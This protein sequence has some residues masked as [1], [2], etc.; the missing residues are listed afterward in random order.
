GSS[1]TMRQQPVRGSRFG[2]VIWIPMVQ[3]DGARGALSLQAFEAGAYEQST[4][5]FAEQVADQASLALRNAWSYSTSE[6]HRRRLEVVNGVGRRLI[7]SLDR[8]SI[9]RALREELALHLQFDVFILASIREVT[10]G[11][12]LAEGYGYDS[13]HEQ[14]VPAVPLAVAGPSREAYESKS[15]V[16]LRSNPWARV[17][18]ARRPAHESFVATDGAAFF[19]SRP[20]HRQR[21]IARSLIWVPV[22]HG[23]RV[24]ALL[25]VQSYRDGAFSEAD[26]KLLQDIAAHVSLALDN[27]DHYGEA[28]TERR[29]L[30]A[31]HVVELGI[32]AAVDERGIAEAVFR[33]LSQYLAVDVLLLVYIDAEARLSGFTLGPSAGFQEIAP[34]PVERTR[35]FARVLATGLTLEESVQDPNPDPATILEDGDD[36]R[37][38]K[39]VLWV[40][41]FQE[42]RAVAA[43]SGQRFADLPFVESDVQL[44]ESAAPVVGIALRTVR[45]HRANQLALDHSLRI[46]E[47]A[48]LA[49]HDLTSTVASIA[50]QALAML[51]SAGVCCWAFDA[52]GRVSG[53]RASGN[54]R[55]ERVLTWAGWRRGAERGREPVSGVAGGRGWMLL[56]LW[57]GDRL[58]G[59][60]G[61]VHG[62]APVGDPGGAELDFARH[63]AVA[64]EN[65]RL[66]AETRG[67]I[68]TLEAVAAFTNLDPTRL[69]RTHAEMARLIERALAPAGALWLMDEDG[70]V[71]AG[72]P[73]RQ[74]P[75]QDGAWLLQAL[76]AERQSPR[77]RD[78]LAGLGGA[79][80]LAAPVILDGLLAGLLTARA[81]EAP[82]NE[83]RRLM[84]VLAGQAGVV[85]G[86]L[87]LVG[88]LERERHM[89]NAILDNSP[90]GVTLQDGGGH[91]VYANPAVERLYGVRAEKIVSRTLESV[92]DEA[93]TVPMSSGDAAEPGA[94]E[95][96]MASP[97]RV[98]RLRTV[99]MP[100]R[101]DEEAEGILSLHEDVT[102]QRQVM[103]AK[104]FMLRAIGHEVRSPAAAMRN[105][106][107]SVIQWEHQID[108]QQRGA[109]VQEAYEMSD[110]LLSLVEGQLI[111]SKLE[112]RHFEPDSTPVHLDQS[113]QQVMAVLAHRY[114][115][116]IEAVTIRLEDGLPAAYCEPTH[117]SQVLTNLVGNALEYTRGS[118]EVAARADGPWLEITVGDDG[119]GLPG[120][121][122]EMLFQKTGA[123]GR[124]RARGGLGLGLYLCRLVVERSFGGR[125]WLDKTGAGATFR[126]TVP[127][128]R[129]A[130]APAPAET[131]SA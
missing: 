91:I 85:L 98:V 38:P 127:S 11:E 90:V 20:G 31:L 125:I 123:A 63:A 109:L 55:A 128:V 50:E 12:P 79:D 101:G 81:G 17:V 1:V 51:G 57:Y 40:P 62:S 105:M 84:S 32:A 86:R 33:G 29:R 43:L 108:S 69:E 70:L 9:M 44:L 74:V 34:R 94:R 131:A 22:L 97:D 117:L 60:L 6:A 114:G 52:E 19:V 120:E 7:S 126:F 21:T 2:S 54:R 65:A 89:M 72:D 93:G 68:W 106:L 48:A 80:L 121:G 25:S 36:R 28:Q 67:R 46:Q 73:G 95:V 107:A 3:A 58:V 102:Q 42:G 99:A 66:A 61:S 59:A 116:R 18:E 96:R 92:L 8:W 113:V 115:G 83:T 27:A 26:V 45:L 13:G 5:A 124:N 119:P 118:I 103:E 122:L 130:G 16:L 24:S 53:A 56:P 71:L 15:P 77:L 129:G 82:R 39:R 30:E 35:H 112:T 47:V 64:M 76:R 111:I 78:F 23:D 88:A 87:R 41:V 4:V 75:L 100:G 10:E 104:D 110:R 37:L 49:G 14:R